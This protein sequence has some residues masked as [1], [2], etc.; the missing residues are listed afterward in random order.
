MTYK[1]DLK[2]TIPGIIDRIN[3]SFKE[4]FLETDTFHEGIAKIYDLKESFDNTQLKTIQEKLKHISSEYG[5]KTFTDM[6]ICQG[7]SGC[8]SKLPNIDFYDEVFSPLLCIEQDISH[9]LEKDSRTSDISIIS[10]EMIEAL[11]SDVYQLTG[12]SMIFIWDGFIYC[13]F[14]NYINESSEKFINKYEH[15]KHKVNETKKLLRN[16][17]NANFVSDYLGFLP[18]R[19]LDSFESTEL[20][21]RTILSNKMAKKFKIMNS[22]NLL[23][24]FN[25]FN[26]IQKRDCITIL[27]MK[28]IH[29]DTILKIKRT[30]DKNIYKTIYKSLSSKLQKKLTNISKKR[31]REEEENEEYLDQNESYR[32][33]IKQSKASLEAKKIAFRKLKNIEDSNTGDAKSEK[34]LNGFL[35]IPFKTLTKEHIYIEKDKLIKKTNSISDGSDIKSIR[36]INKLIKENKSTQISNIKKQLKKHIENRKKYITKIKNILDKA[37]YGHKEPKLQIERFITKWMNG[38]QKGFVLG[39]STLR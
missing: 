7:K 5:T 27:L 20:A 2:K 22:K 33:R 1:E 9:I 39:I 16:K 23:S 37:V 34:F 3:Q 13:F 30:C 12:C 6:L 28:N 15:L 4:G 31:K 36:D 21:N 24:Q 17:V 19:D 29:K 14:G 35:D 38:D 32:K 11:N 8:I 26:I 25:T 18:L 10:S